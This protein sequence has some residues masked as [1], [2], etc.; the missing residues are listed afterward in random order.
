MDLQLRD[1]KYFEMVASLG[2]MGQAS[3]KLRRT[4]PTLT[5]SI[6][7]LEQE[8]GSPLF[9]REGRGI[10]LTAVGEVLLVR[11]RLLQ[12]SVDETIREVSDSVQ[13]YSGHVRIGTGPIAADDVLP[14]ICSLLLSEVKDVTIEITVAQSTGLREQL[15]LGQI[16]LLMGLMPESDS[17]FLCHP[18]VD[19][20][21]VVAAAESHPVFKL[22][23]VTMRA[24]LSYSWVLPSTSIPSRAWLDAAFESHN[25]P[26]PSTRIEANSIALL[27]RLIARNDL[28]SF[29]SRHT[30]GPGQRRGL[31]E[32]ELKE[33]TLIRKLGVSQRRDGYLSPAAQKLL[34]LLRTR[35]PELFSKSRDPFA[36]R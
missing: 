14:E 19:D 28:L 15:R 25:L 9:E 26:K 18:I 2:H 32:V 22:P 8:I 21:V 16:D 20:V 30:L 31:K 10:R 17:E 24:L 33:T 5:K 36:Q 29:I 34:T 12:A 7:R 11:A 6:Q 23:R 35:G 4:Q 3:K 1:L 13:G 27:P